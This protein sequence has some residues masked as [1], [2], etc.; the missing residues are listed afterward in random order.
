MAACLYDG[1]VLT[2]VCWRCIGVCCLSCVVARC[3]VFTQSCLLLLVFDMAVL[4]VVVWCVLC[5]ACLE[6]CMFDCCMNE[7]V[8]LVGA[9]LG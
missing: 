1:C 3:M 7:V 6:C 4:V 2:G 5:V 9:V 8:L